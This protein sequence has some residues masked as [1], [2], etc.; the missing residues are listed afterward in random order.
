[1]GLFWYDWDW[2]AAEKACLKAIEIDPN[3]SDFHG[4]Y[5]M[6]LS[7]AGRQAEAIAESKLS[8]ELNRSTLC[9]SLSRGNSCCM[10]GA[11]TKSLVRLKKNVDLEPTFGCLT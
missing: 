4:H 6:V 11:S 2:A 8:C 3:N 7:S 1:M 10:P 5:A 9:K